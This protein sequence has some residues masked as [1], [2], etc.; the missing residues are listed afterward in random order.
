MVQLTSVLFP[1]LQIVRVSDTFSEP[2]LA[3]DLFES[4]LSKLS[5]LRQ[6]GSE[7]FGRHEANIKK[8][9]E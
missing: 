3:T 6:K 4:D 2:H 8:I 7:S 1:E 9:L 5:L